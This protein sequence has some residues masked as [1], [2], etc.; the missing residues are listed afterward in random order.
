[1]D[2]SKVR[3]YNTFTLYKDS[4]VLNNG[5]TVYI[6]ILPLLTSFLILPKEP[7]IRSLA[8]PLLVEQD[9]PSKLVE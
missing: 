9:R 8:S 3:R 7:Y 1:M 5:N 2:R 6:E 4:K